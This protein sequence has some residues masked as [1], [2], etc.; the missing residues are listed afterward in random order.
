VLEVD[1][2]SVENIDFLAVHHLRK[3]LAILSEM[4]PFKP[5]IVKLSNQIGISRETLMR[6][7]Y[8]LERADLLL[9]LQSGKKGMSKMNKPEKV[10]LNNPN[11]F[12]ALSNR[13]VNTGSIR[14]TFFYNQLRVGHDVLYTASGDFIVDDKYTFEIGGRNKQHKQIRGIKNAYIAPDN[15]EYSHHNRIPLWLFGFLY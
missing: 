4:V 6:Y 13:Q 9:L 15:I 2:P 14:E 1:L 8:L 11:L 12:Y 5:N 3:M 7:L 10:Y